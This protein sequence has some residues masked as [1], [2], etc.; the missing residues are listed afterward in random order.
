MNALF[1]TSAFIEL[2]LNWAADPPRWADLVPG[3][4]AYRSIPHPSPRHT[5]QP[6][7]SAAPI[8]KCSIPRSSFLGV[9]I[10][11][12]RRR[13]L[14]RSLIRLKRLY[15]LITRTCFCE[16][17][18]WLRALT[19]RTKIINQLADILGTNRSEV[20]FPRIG[21]IVIPESSWSVLGHS[22]YRLYG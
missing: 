3:W 7:Q 10:S 9:K 15:S 20:F 17:F 22:G 11:E 8:D 6:V 4:P 5:M 14:P 21:E 12:L 18:N 1:F 16:F 13:R 2:L 19:S